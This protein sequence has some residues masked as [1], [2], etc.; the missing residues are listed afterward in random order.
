MKKAYELLGL[1]EDAT[2]E[3]VENRYFI[4]LK[5]EKSQRQQEQSTNEVAGP[6]HSE[7]NA[8]YNLIIGLESEKLSTEPKQSKV[9]HFFYYYKFHLISTIIIVLFA[10]F[11]IKDTIDKRNEEARKPPIDLSVTVYGNFYF[12]DEEIFSQ[13]LLSLMPDWK[14]IKV[15]PSF[16]P[17]QFSSE[18]D[19]AYQQKAMLLFMTE[20]DQ[21][22]ILDDT[23]FQGMA[24]QG[25]F[26]RLDEMPGWSEL[27][28]PAERIVS[29][30]T[31]EDTE[32]HPY[33]IDLS[34]NRIFNGIQIIDERPILTI[35][36]AEEDWDKTMALV[37]RILNA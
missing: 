31:S 24:G 26:R 30:Q 35:R 4:L 25:A 21:L 8:A 5:K 16:V 34:G 33:G 1:H 11:M 29:I 20:Y 14:R 2:R 3:Q 12:M 28:V 6:T 19:L 9:S 37:K 7:I 23:N 17:P 32:A 18:Q 15:T 10:G 36:A 13:N 22:Y 27:N